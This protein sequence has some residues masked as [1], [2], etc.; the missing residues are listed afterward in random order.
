MVDIQIPSTGTN[1]ITGA[2]R[3]STIREL[4]KVSLI[5]LSTYL[6]MMLVR[7]TRPVVD[8]SIA[9][10]PETHLLPL[11][12]RAMPEDSMNRPEAPPL[13]N[14]ADEDH[15]LAMTQAADAPDTRL[16]LILRGTF[17]SADPRLAYAIIA[18]RSGGE[19]YY[20]V[21]DA[22][23]DGI[24]VQRIMADKVILA[25]NQRYETLNFFPGDGN[26]PAGM[27]AG[28]ASANT[29]N[30]EGKSAERI[31]FKES[32]IS[33]INLVDPQPVRKDGRFVGFHL[34][35]LNNKDLLYR[36]G[37]RRGDIVTWVNEVSLDNPLKGIH[38]L[39]SISSGDYVN[40]TVRRNGRDYS[41]S[42]QM[43]Q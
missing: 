14:V 10:L 13:T 34:K 23:T 1:R 26:N 39:R 41:L 7:D 35:P 11:T 21:G 6:I 4:L 30:D 36:S 15:A 8:P 37:L 3:Q 5:L 16:D 27:E 38:V 31:L 19:A 42:F 20:R 25:H 33:L 22:V 40:M 18:N 17:S 32:R 24:T 29:L 43:P 28:P 2:A 9:P 12:S